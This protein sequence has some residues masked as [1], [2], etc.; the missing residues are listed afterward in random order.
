MIQRHIFYKHF[1]VLSQTYVVPNWIYLLDFSTLTSLMRIPH[2]EWGSKTSDQYV[3]MRIAGDGALFLAG[4]CTQF[5]CIQMR[6]LHVSGSSLCTEA[7]LWPLFLT[8]WWHFIAGVHSL[9]VSSPS[10]SWSRMPIHFPF[11]SSV[12]GH[13]WHRNSWII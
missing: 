3:Y 5:H 10:L 2:S 12:M 13:R 11:I 9:L 8:S 6:R 1:C 7:R 4:T